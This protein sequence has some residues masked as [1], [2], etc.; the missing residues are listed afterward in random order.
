MVRVCYIEESR[1]I[2]KTVELAAVQALNRKKAFTFKVTIFAT[3]E[4]HGR[5][6]KKRETREMRWL[7]ETQNVRETISKFYT[8][9]SEHSY[10]CT[11]FDMITIYEYLGR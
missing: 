9:L 6:P 8:S 11:H 3:A 4:N 1:A 5:E 7:P 10:I 2:F